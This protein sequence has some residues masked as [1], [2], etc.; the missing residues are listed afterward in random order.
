[1]SQA[2]LARL[3]LPPATALSGPWSHAQVLEHLE[4]SRVPLRLACGSRD[5]GPLVASL[6]FLAE[7]DVLWCATQA[8]A[9]VAQLLWEDPRCGF[10]VAPDAPPYHGVRGQGRAEIVPEQGDAV[11]R[12]LIGRYLGGEDGPLARWL[13][14]RPGT[15]VAIR[16]EPRRLLSWDYRAR[17]QGGAGGTGR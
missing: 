13:L 10:E 12:R 7:R 6:W 1:M 15:E 16:I 9:R 17:M 5:G 2:P 4:R 11:L 14:G 3:E 8:S